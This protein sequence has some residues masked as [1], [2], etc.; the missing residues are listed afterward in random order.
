MNQN[1]RP[2]RQGT[3]RLSVAHFLIALVAWL[4]CSP[5]VD[6]IAYGDLIDASLLTLTLLSAVLAVGARRRTLLT[7]AVLVTPPVTAMWLN[8]F[9]HGL[10]PKEFLMVGAGV[11]FVFVIVHLLNFILRAPWVNAEVLCASVATYLMIALFW[12]FAYTLVGRLIPDSF[13]FSGPAP[14]HSMERFNSLYF[15]FCTLTTVGYGDI[16]PVSNAARMLAMLEATIGILYPTVLIARLVG[17]YSSRR[18]PEQ[19]D[20]PSPP[21][22]AG[23]G[24]E[25][26]QG[27][28][29][30]EVQ[31]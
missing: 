11:F 18:P 4:A 27:Y 15:S 14:S 31:P 12:A 25:V 23:A 13:S 20:G 30:K 6:Q 29:P 24:E 3:R 10:I 8:H 9:W 28:C 26:R 17:L 22:G 2:V 1:G 19:T 7:A 5:F 16:S 21:K